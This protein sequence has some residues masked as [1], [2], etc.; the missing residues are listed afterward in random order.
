MSVPKTHWMVPITIV[1][2]KEDQDGDG[3]RVKARTSGW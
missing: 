1:R 2:I 3:N